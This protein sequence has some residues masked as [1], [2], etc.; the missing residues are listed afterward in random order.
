M[1]KVAL[2]IVLLTATSAFATDA[3]R[4]KPQIRFQTSDRCI[5]CHNQLTT[6]QGEDVSIG[7]EWRASMM[8]NSARDPYWQASVRRETIDH[9][10]SQALI[11]D[12]CADCHMPVARYEAKLD[13]RLGEVFAHLPFKDDKKHGREAADG[14]DC[15][16]C[17]QISKEKLGTRESFNGGFVLDPPD[18]SNSRPEY[19]PFKIEAG[20]QRIMNTSTGGFQPTLNEDHIRKSE[21]CATCHTLYTSALGPGG[22]VI[23]E[24]P[25]QMPYPE[26]LHSEYK[27]T[28]TCQSCHMPKVEEP[29]PITR[30]FGVPREGLSRHAFVAA[31]F[32][33]LRMLNAYRGDLEVAALPQEL[34]AGADRTIAFL[35]QKSAR[36]AITDVRVAAGGLQ[37]DVA[38]ENLG[39]HKLPTAYPSR[40]AWLHVTVRDRNDRVLFESGA[41][42]AD[43][44]IVGNDNDADPHR[45]EPHYTQIDSSEQVQI[46]EDI[47]GDSD[48]GATTA[49]LDGVRYLKDNRLL[50][51]GFD[52]ESADP[53]IAVVGG[54]NEDPNFTGTGHRIRYSVSLADGAQ[55]PYRVEAELW[56]QPIGYRWAGNLKPYESAS[57]EARRFGG[58]FDSMS[59]SSGILMARATLLK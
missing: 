55:G 47:I 26:W 46:Y 17:H 33:V 8:A 13:G 6:P 19:G 42:R 10:E 56:Y 48:G 30:V 49:L 39:G 43:G 28:Q 12:G 21:L 25:E 4:N 54:A 36:V 1:M 50:P 18:S 22:K 29:T 2:S 16:V 57:P 45:F 38:V 31:N 14:V 32:F 9:P 52:K 59:S 34:S 41:L 44:S 23:G 3:G 40:R 20:Q 35:Q 53:D 37:A 24:F 15:S 27:E 5:A 7:F 11:Q 51:H 58:Y